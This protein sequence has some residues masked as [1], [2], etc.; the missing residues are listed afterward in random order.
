MISKIAGWT[1]S[2]WRKIRSDAYGNSM[3]VI[4]RAHH[5]IHDGNHYFIAGYD[6]L[7]T[8]DTTIFAVTAPSS[9]KRIHM[10]FAYSANKS[11]TLQVYEDADVTGGSSA[12]LV[13]ND[14]NSAN[15]S[16]LTVVKN[17]TVND[18]GNLLEEVKIGPS[19]KKFSGTE[20]INRENEMILK[21]GSTYIYKITANEDDCV[22]AYKGYWY[23]IEESP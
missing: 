18:L 14:R 6:E 21:A 20:D 7:D 17:P 4:E 16:E 12:T 22:L 1:G 3:G 10:T 15:T 23:E 13:N 11:Y 8:G 9:A 5:A 2:A 19:G